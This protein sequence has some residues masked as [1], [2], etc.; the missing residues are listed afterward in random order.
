VNDTQVDYNGPIV[1]GFIDYDLDD[2]KL[3]CTKKNM[4]Q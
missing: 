4:I 1:A 2:L 3:L